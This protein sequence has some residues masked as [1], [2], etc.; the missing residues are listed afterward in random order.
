MP[1]SPML[2]SEV[3]NFQQYGT[4]PPVE[5]SRAHHLNFGFNTVGSDNFPVVNWDCPTRLPVV[6]SKTQTWN[7]P[8]FGTAETGSEGT[9]VY[10]ALVSGFKIRVS[11]TLDQRKGWMENL[12]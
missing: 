2:T 12:A 8:L 9:I 7:C 3:S 11:F 6:E 5:R 10:D 4:F 1:E